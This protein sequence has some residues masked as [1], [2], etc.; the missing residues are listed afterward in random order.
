MNKDKLKLDV[1][2]LWFVVWLLCFMCWI[3][4]NW[5]LMHPGYYLLCG[6]CVHCVKF[7]DFGGSAM[8]CL[9]LVI[10][11]LFIFLELLINSLLCYFVIPFS[12][13]YVHHHFSNDHQDK[14]QYY[15]T[16]TTT[17][18][19]SDFFFSVSPNSHKYYWRIPRSCTLD[20]EKQWARKQP[21][22]ICYNWRQCW[23]GTFCLKNERKERLLL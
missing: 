3:M 2:W 18:I 12:V 15:T 6:T 16:T 1:S 21:Q 20:K 8:Y 13:W 17:T 14:I 5:C 9:Y 7:G 23:S 10:V 4:T 11:Y 19:K 22:P